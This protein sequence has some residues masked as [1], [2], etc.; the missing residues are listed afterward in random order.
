MKRILLLFFVAVGN[1]SFGQTFLKA[2][3]D[4]Y[5]TKISQNISVVIST[6]TN[7]DIK[8]PKRKLNQ[9]RK[10][11]LKV[12]NQQVKQ[13]DTVFQAYKT[14]TGFD[15]NT[16][17]SV[18]IIYQTGIETNL[19]DFLIYSGKDTIS[20]GELWFVEPGRP[21][22]KTI[23]YKSFFDTTKRAEGYKVVDLRDSLLRIAS[24]GTCRTVQLQLKDHKVFDGSSSTILK[25][26]KQ[27]GRYFFDEC[28]LPPFDFV[29]IWR[30]E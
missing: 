28:T 7:G 1:I 13:F 20:Y 19:R 23:F 26:N 25:A 16:A 30:K 17:D 18:K 5:K 29:P 21:T 4:F 8:I 27:N 11:S 9:A 2:Y 12:L 14:K 6:P 3:K 22:I 15:F 10:S 24:N